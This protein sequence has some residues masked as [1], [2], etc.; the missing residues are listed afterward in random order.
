MK[1]SRKI[2]TS[3]PACFKKM[4]QAYKKKDNF[5][6]SDDAQTGI[7]PAFSTLLDMGRQAGL[8][9]QQWLGVLSSLGLAGSGLWLVRAA[10]LDPEPT[11]KLSLM[12]GGGVVCLVCGGFSAIRILTGLVPPSVSANPQGFEISW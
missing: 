7:N 9:P 2:K 1:K 6:F 11:S 5:I 3:D 12:A 10:V 4:A 8:G